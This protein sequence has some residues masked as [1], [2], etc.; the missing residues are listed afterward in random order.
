VMSMLLRCDLERDELGVDNA[1][2]AVFTEVLEHLHY[3]YAP[4]VLSRISRALKPGGSTNTNNAEHSIA[5]QKTKT[6]TRH[7]THIPVPREGVHNEGSGI[8][9]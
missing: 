5:I 3:Y 1:D 4:L 6:I 7:S 8:T 2:C 9:T